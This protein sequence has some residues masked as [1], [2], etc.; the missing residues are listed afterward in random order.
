MNMQHS[1]LTHAHHLYTYAQTHTHTTSTARRLYGWHAPRSC[2]SM[3]SGGPYVTHSAC[4]HDSGV[5]VGAWGGCTF[6]RN[7]GY[8]PVWGSVYVCEFV[9]VY[10][11]LCSYLCMYVCVCVLV[12]VFPVKECPRGC[13]FVCM[14]QRAHV[15]MSRF[16]CNFA[17][18][19]SM[20]HGWSCR[21]IQGT[22][23]SVGTS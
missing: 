20:K 21:Y 6:D 23:K 11:C 17:L 10:M 12:E 13:V 18:K 15:R 9:C 14:C 4:T 19:Q 16:F 5:R 1:V 7:E 22:A 2:W 8:L 3:G